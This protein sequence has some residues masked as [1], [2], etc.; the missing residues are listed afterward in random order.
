MF[1]RWLPRAGVLAVG[2]AAFLAA[3]APARA[4]YRGYYYANGYWWAYDTIP[5]NMV[6]CQLH[7]DS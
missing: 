2:L 6:I 4:Q 1:R 7:S 3:P 5:L